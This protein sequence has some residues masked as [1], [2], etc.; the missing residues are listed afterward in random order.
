METP[1]QTL[2]ELRQVFTK[3]AGEDKQVY[4]QEFQ[5]ALGL[6]DEYFADRLFAIFD[7]D[8]S[9]YIQIQEFLTNVENLVLTTTEKK[10]KFAY[11]LHDINQDDSIEK[12]EISHLITASLNEKNLNFKP[13]QINDLV[14]LFFLE[15]DSDN[16]GKI[17]FAE[18]KGLISKF[19]DLIEAMT[20]SPVSWLRPHKQ[21]S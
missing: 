20:V 2:E 10:L 1:R 18:F 16:S 19:P 17:S 21:N 4:P 6:K 14:D 15:A 12:D 7:T 8:K 11:Q 5:K 9:G 3:I 13:E